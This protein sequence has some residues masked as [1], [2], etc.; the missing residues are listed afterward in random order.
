MFMILLEK[1]KDKFAVEV[2]KIVVRTTASAA[3]ATITNK[4]INEIHFK[5]KGE[6]DKPKDSE[7]EKEDE[8]KSDTP[9]E[10]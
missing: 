6:N 3:A 9:K 5:L 7:A 8:K 1:G 4:I 10:D 2:A